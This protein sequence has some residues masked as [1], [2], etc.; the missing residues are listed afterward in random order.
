MAK[1]LFTDIDGT[2]LDD[3]KHSIKA[4]SLWMQ[5]P[6]YFPSVKNITST[7]RPMMKLMFCPKKRTPIWNVIAARLYANTELTLN[8]QAL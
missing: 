1:I 2:L 5:L 7:Y 8:F 3:K 4:G 6:D